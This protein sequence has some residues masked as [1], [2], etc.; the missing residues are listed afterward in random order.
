M[1]T[2]APIIKVE[3]EVGELENPKL[4]GL[5]FRKG[6]DEYVSDYN[7]G[8]NRDR[9]DDL[10]AA[11]QTLSQLSYTPN[12]EILKIERKNSQF[13]A[14]WQGL[15]MQTCFFLKLQVFGVEML[16]LVLT[17]RGHIWFVV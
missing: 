11:S 4:I 3:Q 5:K 16:P 9:T 15:L 2:C 13:G 7:G 14:A 12:T 1:I 17:L 8:G 6:F 10:L